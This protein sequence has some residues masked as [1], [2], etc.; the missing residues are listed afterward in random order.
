MANKVM[1]LVI[2]YYIISVVSIIAVLNLIQ[3][4]SR[5]RYKTEIQNLDIE[6]N[7]II[8]APIMTEL[9]KVETL[10]KT[11]TIKDKYNIWKKEIDELKKDLDS[12]INDMILDADFSLEQ[13][14]YKDYIKKKINVEI[15][16]YEAKEKKARVFEEIKEITLSEERNR[17]TIT[18]LK[19]EF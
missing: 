2:T 11:K 13:K 10:T 14:D 7:E 18:D 16:L 3:Y 4:L 1:L 19:T 5:K 15:K 17:V 6:K 8:D 9:S 12:S